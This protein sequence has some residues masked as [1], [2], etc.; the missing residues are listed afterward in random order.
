MLIK[1]VQTI[2]QD[3]SP[4]S[5]KEYT[6]MCMFIFKKLFPT[7]NPVLYNGGLKV[8]KIHA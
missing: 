2:L 7:N 4:I 3:I 1:L 5:E 6:S 8:L